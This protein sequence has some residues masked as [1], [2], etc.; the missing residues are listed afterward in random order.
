MKKLLVLGI[1]VL[2]VA[3]CSNNSNQSSTDTSSEPQVATE[4]EIIEYDPHR[5]EG[6]FKDVEVSPALDVEMAAKGESIFSVKCG[7]CHKLSDELL[8]GPGFA[9]VSERRSATWMMN[10]LTNTDE[11]IDLDPELQAQLEICMVRMP[12]QNLSDEDARSIYEFMR[13]NDGVK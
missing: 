7:S 1:S 5:G 9:G 8:V 11:M 3:A 2:F 12:N 6:K 13:K 10:F 4:A